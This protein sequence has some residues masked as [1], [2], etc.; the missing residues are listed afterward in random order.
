MAQ[1]THK[2]TFWGKP[3]GEIRAMASSNGVQ[4]GCVVEPDQ[5]DQRVSMQSVEV[6]GTKLRYSEQGTGQPVVLVHGGTS[7]LRTWANQLQAFGRRHRTVAYSCRHYRPNE[8]IAD[9][10]DLSLSTLAEDLAAFL[11]AV[12]LAPA[13][14]VGH[15]QGAFI[16]L[17]LALREPELVRSLVLAEPP[18]LPLLGLSV[19]PKPHELLRLIVRS[20]RTAVAVMRFAAKGI[21]PA[22]RAFARGDDHRGL[23]IFLKAVLGRD[24]FAR[25]PEVRRQQARENVKPFKAGL[26]GGFPS[27]SEGDARNVTVPTLLVTGECS[28]AVLHRI[29][30]RLHKLMPRVERVTIQDASHGMYEDQPEAFNQAVLEFLASTGG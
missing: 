20:P 4:T 23:E 21:A 26:R 9:G 22:T 10:A 29:T 18:A 2:E 19:P 11:R 17:L 5:S 15:S 25:L 24:A 8:E 27:F 12:D 6:N 14:L 7:D 30:D 13:H 1:Q 3:I 16:C 28:A